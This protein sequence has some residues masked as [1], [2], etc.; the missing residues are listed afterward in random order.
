[1]SQ[2]SDI[3]RYLQEWG[4]ITPMEALDQFGCFRLAARIYDL[5]K[6]H[7]ITEMDVTENGKRF[8]LYHLED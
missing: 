8:A 1:M 3:L 4:S 6:K 7:R 2:S 5:R